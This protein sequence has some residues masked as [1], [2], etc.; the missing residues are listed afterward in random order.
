METLDQIPILYESFSLG[1][2]MSIS[3]RRL[4]GRYAVVFGMPQSLRM[5]KLKRFPLRR[6]S[7]QTEH[8][9]QELGFKVS[10]QEFTAAFSN[11][12][13]AKSAPSGYIFKVAELVKGN[14]TNTSSVNVDF[15]A[16]VIDASQ[17]QGA[18]IVAEEFL[19]VT[20]VPGGVHNFYLP[21]SNSPTAKL[22]MPSHD[23]NLILQLLGYY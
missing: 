18:N 9:M 23:W 16:R 7:F 15:R 1:P 5:G 12:V 21:D 10:F 11:L 22:P 6:S 17:P 20:V 14:Y 3:A 2:E 8:V 4:R 13:Y 19:K